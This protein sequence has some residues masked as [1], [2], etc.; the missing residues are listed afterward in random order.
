MLPAF[1]IIEMKKLK[2]IIKNYQNSK[3]WPIIYWLVIFFSIFL[4]HST[5]YLNSDEGV[6]LGG[7]W[8]LFNSRQL[9]FDFFAFIPPAGF[10]LVYF[11][12]KVFGVGF[13]PAQILADVI[14]LF[15]VAGVFAIS[16]KV[17]R[18]L[19]NYLIPVFLVFI[20]TWFWLINHNIFNIVCLI[21]ASYFILSYFKSKKPISIWW[22]GLL[23]GLGMLFL[24]QKG[25][26]FFIATTF[27]ILLDLLFKKEFGSRFKV[28][29]IYIFSA[30][31]PLS[32]LLYWP[33]DVLYAHLIDFPLFHYIEANRIS[34]ARL[35]LFF[36][37]W[38]A[39]F[40]FLR[41]G[42]RQDLNFLLYLQAFLLFACV[43]LPDKYHL[44]LSLFP[45]ISLSIFL[46]IKILKMKVAEKTVLATVLLV[47]FLQLTIPSIIYLKDKWW[48]PFSFRSQKFIAY[49]KN[50]CQSPYLFVG[51][52][53]PSLY[54]ESGKINATKFDILI[55]GHQTPEQFQL[56]LNDLVKNK[57]DCAILAYADPLQRFRHDRDNIVERYIRDEYQIVFD[58]ENKLYFYKLK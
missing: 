49:I 6:L 44:F 50:N 45:L 39:V 14:W 7:A 21:W 10:Y 36:F 17:Y 12:W 53:F 42:K 25:L 13:W 1:F 2:I 57:P 52:F 20:S 46:C 22:A 56:A 41:K 29:L 54:F 30:L 24:Q 28:L 37:V 32:V 38:L 58:V 35:Y 23:S 27:Y 8:N 5:H 3:C 4:F 26:V 16:Q 33:P 43:P 34:Y 15:G 11:C 18:S 55:S 51:P 31:I 48:G 19:L 47:F 40:L 9:Y